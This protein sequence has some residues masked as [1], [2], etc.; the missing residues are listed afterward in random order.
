MAVRSDGECHFA[1]D[2]LG[3]AAA[4]VLA[5]QALAA[6][7]ADAARPAPVLLARGGRQL[8]STLLAARVHLVEVGVGQVG[9]MGA[10][11]AGRVAIVRAELRRHL[12]RWA[13]VGGDVLLQGGHKVLQSKNR[14]KKA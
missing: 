7:V 8:L 13:R 11:A 10:V 14:Q 5:G 1:I 12:R 9:Q 6:P 2:L 4:R 3:N